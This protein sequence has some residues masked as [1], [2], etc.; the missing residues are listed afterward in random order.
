MKKRAF[1]SFDYDNDKELKNSLVA[2]ANNSD[3]P[4]EIIDMSIKEA[5]DANWKAYARRRIKQCDIV[6]VICGYFT[7]RANGVATE[8]GIAKEEHVPYFLLAGHKDYVQKP[9]GAEYD[10]VYRWTWENLK[11]LINNARY[12]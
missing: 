4:F 6:I 5:V 1:I 3:S 10:T 7:D 12:R 11:A 9:K 2:Q 8:L